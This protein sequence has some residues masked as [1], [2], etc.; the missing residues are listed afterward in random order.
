MEAF[1]EEV[2][3]STAESRVQRVYKEFNSLREFEIAA[4]QSVAELGRFLDA[5]FRP[6]S[7]EGVTRLWK[8]R[9]G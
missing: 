2:K 5:S 6:A 8:I 4:M 3:R 1:R 7:S 9:R